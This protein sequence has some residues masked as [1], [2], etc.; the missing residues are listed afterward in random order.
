MTNPEADAQGLAGRPVRI[1]LEEM[2]PELAAYFAG[3]T[4]LIWSGE[5]RKWWRPDAAGYTSDRAQA[6]RY[7]LADAYARTR[8]CD[9][10]KGIAFEQEIAPRP[11]PDLEGESRT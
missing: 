3:D 4:C 11:T 9:P 10:S 6:G 1:P 2:L 8:H 7:L 5:W